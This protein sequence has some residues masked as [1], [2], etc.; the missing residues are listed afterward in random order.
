MMNIYTLSG[1][2]YSSRLRQE[3]I[4]C[5]LAHS[6]FKSNGKIGGK[7]IIKGVISS[8]YKFSFRLKFPI[9]GGQPAICMALS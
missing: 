6:H 8:F 2:C 3:N 7:L 9:I 4:S 5:Q 1:T